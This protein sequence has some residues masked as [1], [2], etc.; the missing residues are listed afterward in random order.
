MIFIFVYMW[1]CL[2]ADGNVG[3]GK[4]TEMFVLIIELSESWYRGEVVVGCGF[5]KI[6][7][8]FPKI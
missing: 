5:F 4:R 2:A 1:Y 3:R 8:Y 7:A 6:M